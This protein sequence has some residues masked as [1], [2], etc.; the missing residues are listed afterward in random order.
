[1]DRALTRISE[2]NRLLGFWALDSP[3][4]DSGHPSKLTPTVT[5]HIISS[6][7]A[8]NAVQV[9]KP[10]RISKLP[11][12]LKTVLEIEGSRD[13]AVVKKKKPILVKCI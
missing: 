6:R 1:M 3:G 11:C 7:K 10:F 2:S 8:E 13:E 4:H 9:T 5:K 12:P